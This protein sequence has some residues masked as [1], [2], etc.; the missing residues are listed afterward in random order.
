MNLKDF[1]EGLEIEQAKL[2]GFTNWLPETNTQV[3]HGVAR[4]NDGKVEKYVEFWYGTRDQKVLKIAE[5]MDNL[6]DL[7]CSKMVEKMEEKIYNRKQPTSQE[8]RELH[9]W[10]LKHTPPINPYRNMF[11]RKNEKDKSKRNLYDR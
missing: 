6:D 3:A 5:V 10:N 11:V 2:D 8:K 9:E 4:V 7:G 1:K